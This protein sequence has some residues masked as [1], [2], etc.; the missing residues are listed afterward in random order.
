MIQMAE[1]FMLVAIAMLLLVSACSQVREIPMD[2]FAA[3]DRAI[4]GK[5]LREESS[6]RPATPTLSADDMALLSTPTKDPGRAVPTAAYRKELIEFQGVDHTN[7][8][9]IGRASGQDCGF[10]IFPLTGINVVPAGVGEYIPSLI[11]L[12]PSASEAYHQALLNSNADFLVDVRVS[13]KSANYLIASHSC[14][15][16]TGMAAKLINESR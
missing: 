12:S 10:S 5:S 16:V 14:I 6:A 3:E 13:K 2:Q 4:V 1:R 8:R 11:Q 9:I 7:Y 15:Q